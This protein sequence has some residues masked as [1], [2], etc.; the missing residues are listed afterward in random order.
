MAYR[1][2]KERILDFLEKWNFKE[3]NA[4]WILYEKIIGNYQ[5]ERLAGNPLLL[6]LICY[7]SEKTKLGIPKSITSFYEES[8]KCLLED[9]EDT[10]KISK[11]I[12]TDSEIKQYLL[13]EI[14]YWQYSNEK[15]EF[16][17]E[18]IKDIIKKFI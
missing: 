4:K 6:T 15:N 7:L 18:E 11:R 14:A 5:L 1:L 2:E 9:W 16:K 8:I 10:K 17:Y 13:E 3:Q 12:Y